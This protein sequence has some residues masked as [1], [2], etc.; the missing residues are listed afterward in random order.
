MTT[1]RYRAGKSPIEAFQMTKEA[2]TN[3]KFWPDW[4]YQARNL[5]F[6]ENGSVQ[7]LTPTATTG[8]LT[9]TLAGREVLIRWDYWII[10]NPDTG[11]IDVLT[12]EQFDTQFEVV[13]EYHPFA[14]VNKALDWAKEQRCYIEIACDGSVEVQF[15]GPF[16]DYGEFDAR[17]GGET[18]LQAISYARSF[19]YRK[20]QGTER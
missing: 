12:P 8:L 17:V 2:R 10:H 7:R 20:L 4:L 19:Y 5:D 6:G 14:D 16:D 9:L 15:E 1:Y 3:W 13:P 18:L 11:H